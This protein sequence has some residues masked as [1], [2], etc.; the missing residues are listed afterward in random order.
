MNASLNPARF[1]D[2][3]VERPPHG[4][5]DGDHRT[6]ASTERASSLVD[7]VVHDLR[8]PA[9]CIQALVASCRAHPDDNDALAWH[10]A[11]IEEQ[12]VALLATVASLL[13]GDTGEDLVADLADCA[14]DAAASIRPTTR[15]DLVVRAPERVLVAGS[16]T[17]L[18]RALVNLLHNACRAAG[19]SGRV[20]L[21]I[22][23]SDTS[24]CVVVE[25]D[26]PGF[27]AVEPQNFIGL[28]AA[29][30]GVRK[31]GGSLKIGCSGSLGGAQVTLAL[32][33]HA[34]AR[35]ATPDGHRHAVTP[36]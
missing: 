12:A 30:R 15:C 4:K 17:D 21:T 18:R 11:R 24:V 20:R 7:E 5:L 1:T 36:V 33:P 14:A 13:I 6:V 10:L 31:A 3:V 23:E 19:P 34:G 27:G 25:D 9:A 16:P 2:L 29:A 22:K 35:P 32:R 28:G 26:G 8:Q